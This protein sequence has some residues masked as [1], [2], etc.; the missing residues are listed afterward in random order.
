MKEMLYLSIANE[1]FRRRG[2]ALLIVDQPGV[3]EALRLR[4][5]HMEPDIEGAASACVDYLEK[6]GEVDPERIGILGISLGGYYA[7]RAA[8]FEKRLK[9]AIAWG[10]IWDWHETHEWRLK[11]PHQPQPVPPFHFLWVT[12]KDTMEE[13]Q[14]VTDKLTLVG[15]ADKITCPLLVLH[16]ENDR[17]IPPIMAERTYAAAVNSPN[18][19]LKIFTRADGGCEHVLVDN[20]TLAIDYIADWA[21]DT[22]GGNSK[23]V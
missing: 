16:G 23:G 8:A 2:L 7:P 22:L 15:V 10:A 14:K 18:R 4:N 1:E 17:L 11:Q 13:A 5:L 19:K 3:G 9:C 12:G 21:A 20:M 6:R